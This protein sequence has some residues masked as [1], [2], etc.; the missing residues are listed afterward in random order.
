MR[1]PGVAGPALFAVLEGAVLLAAP[2][3]V[4]VSVSATAQPAIRRDVRRA[5]ASMV[6]L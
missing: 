2:Q 3:A 5:I 6:R 1:S 4:A